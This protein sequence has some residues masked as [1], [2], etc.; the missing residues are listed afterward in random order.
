MPKPAIQQIQLS[1]KVKR[2]ATIL[3]G[4][5]GVARIGQIMDDEVAV[6]ALAQLIEQAIVARQ[7][8]DGRIDWR[9]VAA[10][11]LAVMRRHPK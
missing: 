3:H 10:H 2:A 4:S 9:D 6:N 1:D 5:Q 7:T 11:V 8:K